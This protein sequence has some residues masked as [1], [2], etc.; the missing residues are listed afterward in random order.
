VS[1]GFLMDGLSSVFL[2][3]YYFAIASSTEV[4]VEGGDQPKL[5]RIR[6]VPF[7]TPSSRVRCARSG[8]RLDLS[9]CCHV[10]MTDF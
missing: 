2:A 6:A 8:H 3:E 9:P 5:S 10:C 7:R 4:E 1:S